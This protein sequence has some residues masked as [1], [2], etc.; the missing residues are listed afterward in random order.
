VRTWAFITAAWLLS[1]CGGTEP[2]ELT[3]STTGS[4]SLAQTAGTAELEAGCGDEGLACELGQIC[5]E[6]ECT[7][8]R[9]SD[10]ICPEV[11]FPYCIVIETGFGQFDSCHECLEDSDCPGSRC[12]MNER[13]KLRHCEALTDR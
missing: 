11:F 10:E 5:V 13:I 2:V 7:V 9:C 3:H 4:P 6:G 12:V 1:A 8:V